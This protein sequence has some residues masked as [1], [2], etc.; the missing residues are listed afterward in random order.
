MICGVKKLFNV[1]KVAAVLALSIATTNLFAAVVVKDFSVYGNFIHKK[2]LWVCSSVSFPVDISYDAFSVNFKT[3]EQGGEGYFVQVMPGQYPNPF[4]PVQIDS[5]DKVPHASAIL[6][7]I[8]K[9]AGIYEYIFVCKSNNFCGMNYN[10][11]SVVRVYIVPQLSGYSALTNVCPGTTT[12]V[13]LN[14][15]VPTEI[16][17][18]IE[19]VGWKL[20][21]FSSKGRAPMPLTNVGIMNVGNTEFKYTVDDTQGNYSGKFRAMQNDVYACPR[22]TATVTHTV[23]ISDNFFIPDREVSYCMETLLGAMETKIYFYPN[24]FASIG[25]SVDGGEWILPSSLLLP[26]NYFKDI[27][28]QPLDGITNRFKIPV[29]VLDYMYSNGQFQYPLDIVLNYKY[30]NC[31]GDTITKLTI[32]LTNDLAAVIPDKQEKD[33]CRNQVPGVVDLAGIFGFS[34]PATSGAWFEYNG[35]DWDELLYGTVDISG[36]TTGSLYS[37]KYDISGALDKGDLC[38]VGGSTKLFDLRIRDI[39]L[40]GWNAATK[41]CKDKFSNGVKLNLFN[42]VPGLDSLE[43]KVTWRDT[44]GT[45]ITNPKDYL[46]T[47]QPVDTSKTLRYTFDVKAD[48]G[49]FKGNLYI[50]PIDSIVSGM[51]TVAIQVCWTDDY[52]YN[53]NLHQVIGIAG[54]QGT[55]D[56]VPAESSK[57]SLTSA[58]FDPA[59]GKFKAHDAF[60]GDNNPNDSEL[61][62]FV[63]KP[64][65]GEAC[66]SKNMKVKIKVTK[67]VDPNK[68]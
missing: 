53:I 34:I 59:T 39:A 25:S 64:D 29:E 20:Q 30:P 54:L 7:V 32:R 58:V 12:N 33:V 47:G 1:R 8:G 17:Y 10:E 55:W 2:D 48:C 5:V 27:K 65:N 16:Q 49:E 28:D 24:I 9:P 21:F 40:S 36:F 45:V 22:D 66:V 56:F 38:G 51:D 68:K 4:T 60:D 41:I 52:A 6:N 62:V 37:F 14:M 13:D 46:F 42:Y 19:S 26:E 43:S 23:R 61:Y 18:F 31:S 3:L 11:Q 63:Y 15:Y 44:L 50:T 67:F 35:T 57:P